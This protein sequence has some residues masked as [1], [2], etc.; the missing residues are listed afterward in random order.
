MINNSRSNGI[1]RYGRPGTLKDSAGALISVNH[2][3][4]G[5]RAVTLA[6]GNKYFLYF[7]AD[8]TETQL[9]ITT[10]KGTDAPKW[11]LYV[12]G[13]LDSSGYDDYANP[14]A[15]IS[16]PITLTQ[17]IINGKNTIELRINGK[18]AASTDY[19]LLVK[20]ASIQ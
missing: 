20:G 16:R 2:A 1:N 14:A 9:Q 5:T 12:N 13:V 10:L 11:D 8:G 17:P 3:S 15:N 6:D 7:M 18:N 4:E 19:L